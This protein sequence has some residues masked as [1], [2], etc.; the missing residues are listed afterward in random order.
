MRMNIRR[1]NKFASF[2]GFSFILVYTG[3]S[4]CDLLSVNKDNRAPGKEPFINNL[5][6]F[7]VFRT[8]QKKR[9]DV[10]FVWWNGPWHGTAWLGMAWRSLNHIS[11]HSP[12][13]RRRMIHYHKAIPNQFTKCKLL[14]CAVAVV[15]ST[16]DMLCKLFKNFVNRTEN[17]WWVWVCVCEM[18]C[19]NMSIIIVCSLM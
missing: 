2:Y 9:I 6:V 4:E 8:L 3:I 12:L 15:V 16:L 13:R 14:V 18:K 7:K 11:L 17:E 1:I 19:V 10:V 5:Y